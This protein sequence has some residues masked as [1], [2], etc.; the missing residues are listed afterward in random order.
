MW[1]RPSQRQEKI[2][3]FNFKDETLTETTVTRHSM[4]VR[5]SVTANLNAA[6]KVT[7]T[8]YWQ[9]CSSRN[10]LQAF[11]GSHSVV[12]AAVSLRL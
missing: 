4:P 3:I 2:A 7:L 11:P 6:G 8:R 9:R 1:C 12:G 10:R 5:G